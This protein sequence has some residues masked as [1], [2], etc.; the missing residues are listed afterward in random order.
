L[1]IE[2]DMPLISS[3][4]DELVAMELGAVITRGKPDDVLAHP[5]VV[6]AYLGTSEEVIR[7]SGQLVGSNSQGAS[8]PDPARGDT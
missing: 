6:E 8:A 3:V 1:L 2:H 7:R 5:R 4:S